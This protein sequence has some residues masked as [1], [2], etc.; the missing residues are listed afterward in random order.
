MARQNG[1]ATWITPIAGT[2]SA[3]TGDD[4]NANTTTR[5]FLATE[6]MTVVEVGAIAL[7]SSAPLLTA[8]T[9]TVSKRTAATV[10]NDSVIPVWR[11][12]NAAEGGPGAD[13]SVSNFDNANA[14]ASGAIQPAVAS[15]PAGKIVRAYTEV[16]L[17]KGDM[18]VFKVTVANGAAVQGAFYAKA[19]Y[20]GAGLV[21]ANDTEP[22]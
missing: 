17:D 6:R 19:Y 18:L 1:Q 12:A 16:L 7:L 15:L 3:P 21:E 13:A 2:S 14:I 9:F 22:K 5:T 11:S 10:A 4:M 20:D 8:L